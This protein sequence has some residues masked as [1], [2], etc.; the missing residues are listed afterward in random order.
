MVRDIE[1]IGPCVGQINMTLEWYSPD[2]LHMLTYF[3]MMLLT[4]CP[5]HKM[6]LQESYIISRIHWLLGHSTTRQTPCLPSCKGIASHVRYEYTQSWSL[7]HLILKIVQSILRDSLVFLSFF[8]DPWLTE[9]RIFQPPPRFETSSTRVS[10]KVE[11]QTSVTLEKGKKDKWTRWRWG[12]WFYGD[13][14]CTCHRRP[15]WMTSRTARRQTCCHGRS[16]INLVSIFRCS[17][18]SLHPVYTSRVDPSVLTFSLWFHQTP[19]TCIPFNSRIIYCS[20]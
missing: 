13:T 5:L 15:P 3:W 12:V 17:S 16:L 20:K 1:W 2:T 4:R 6:L 14:R 8:V 18:S 19:R 10:R 7:S 11:G 9:V